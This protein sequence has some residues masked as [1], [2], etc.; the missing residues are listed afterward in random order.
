MKMIRKATFVAISKAF[1]PRGLVYFSPVET[2][3]PNLNWP[4]AALA[5]TKA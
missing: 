4:K 3:D 5:L 1:F 2:I